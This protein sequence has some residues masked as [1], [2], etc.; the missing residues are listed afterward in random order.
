LVEV[1]D[2]KSV[3]KRYLLISQ[4]KPLERNASFVINVTTAIVESVITTN[5]FSAKSVKDTT[6]VLAWIIPL[7]AHV[8]PCI[9]LNVKH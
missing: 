5:S 3:R 7:V 9:V 1:F 8:I 6:V 2:V 4:Q